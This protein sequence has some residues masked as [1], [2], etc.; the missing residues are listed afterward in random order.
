MKP[1]QPRTLNPICVEG[2]LDVGLVSKLKSSPNC[3]LYSSSI[4]TSERTTSCWVR[5]LNEFGQLCSWLQRRGCGD[6]NLTTKQTSYIAYLHVKH[7]WYAHP[8]AL[9][10]VEYREIDKFLE[11]SLLRRCGTEA[12]CVRRIGSEQIKHYNITHSNL[13]CLGLHDSLKCNLL[14]RTIDIK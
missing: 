3:Y 9:A 2:H 10:M 11:G 13:R 1:R 5:G 4:I 14:Q 6:C 7:L 8:S 12:I